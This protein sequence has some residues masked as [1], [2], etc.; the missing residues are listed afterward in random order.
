VPSDYVKTLMKNGARFN[1]EQI[2]AL[3]NNGVPA[4]YI[5]A[6]NLEG[7]EPLDAKAIIELRQRGVSADTARKLRQ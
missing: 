7:R 4:D 1:A 5:A 2:I 6:V 3:R